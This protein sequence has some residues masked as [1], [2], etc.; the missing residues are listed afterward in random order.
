M[1]MKSQNITISSKKYELVF[2]YKLAPISITTFRIIS[3]ARNS[4]GIATK[5]NVYYKKLKPSENH[6]F[7]E[8]EIND[9][10]FNPTNS[11]TIS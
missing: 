9:V 5:A 4:K 1:L 2:Y 8:L 3:S 10:R 11:I 6:V 7:E